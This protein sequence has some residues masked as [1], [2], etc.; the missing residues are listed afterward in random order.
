M[1]PERLEIQFLYQTIIIIAVSYNHESGEVRQTNHDN[2]MRF[3]IRK[4]N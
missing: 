2:E 4:T 1:P 3:K